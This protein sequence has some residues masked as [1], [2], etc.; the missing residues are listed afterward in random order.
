MDACEFALAELRPRAANR[1][2]DDDIALLALVT[3]APGEA[4]VAREVDEGERTFDLPADTTSPSRARAMVLEV[5]TDWGLEQLG[6]SAVLLVSEV[7]TNGV[8]HA[9]TGLRLTLS[10]PAPD[11]VRIAVT[12]WAPRAGV[13]VR[14]S[15]REAE[16]GRGLFLV[17]HL[18]DGWGSL[19][20]DARKTVWFELQA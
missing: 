9:G 17:D 19:A 11:R 12:D 15:S 5:L 8:R 3:R 18:S 6:D 2:Y 14:P 10:R 4:T 20:D 13:H 1:K 7:V 16:G